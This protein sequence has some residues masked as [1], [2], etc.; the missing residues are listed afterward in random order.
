MPQA[1]DRAAQK[2]GW[3]GAIR[4]AVA[5]R[6]AGDRLLVA[7]DGLRPEVESAGAAKT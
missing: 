4:D 3:R 6:G 5:Y 2:T 1:N 7:E